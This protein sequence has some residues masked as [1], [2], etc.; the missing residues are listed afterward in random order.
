PVGATAWALRPVGPETGLDRVLGVR[1]EADNVTPLVAHP[2][3]VP[4]RTVGVLPDVAEHD[5]ALALE[6]VE[7]AFVGHVLAVLVLE[8]DR[9]DL[10]L[11]VLVRPR[12]VGALDAQLLLAA[13]EAAVVVLDHRAG[14][15][16]RLSE[17]LEP[18]ADPE[19]GQATAGCL[20]DRPGSGC[21]A[22]DRPGA[23]VVAVGEA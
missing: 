10:P 23:Q 11:G 5:P 12:G 9:D 21:E 13:H 14:E 2:G 16:V 3:D 17:D 18:V 6:L 20:D 22:A 19:H 8:R 4:P 1:H 15:Q 7:G